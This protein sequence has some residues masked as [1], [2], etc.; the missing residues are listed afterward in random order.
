MTIKD[1]NVL[2]AKETAFNEDWKTATAHEQKPIPK[3]A[4][5]RFIQK[6]LNFYGNWF[7]VEYEDSR[8]YVDP[9]KFD[10]EYIVDTKRIFNIEANRHT[11]IITTNIGKKYL[12]KEDGKELELL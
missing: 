4:K 6:Y 3:G 10:G 2:T 12:V 5:V 9:E 1:L 11:I 7:I 8:Y